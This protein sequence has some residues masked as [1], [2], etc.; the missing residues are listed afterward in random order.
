[1]VCI[2][3]KINFHPFYTF[4]GYSVFLLLVFHKFLQ[5]NMCFALQID[6]D[7]HD[8][9]IGLSHRLQD[10]CSHWSL[11]LHNVQL[12]PQNTNRQDAKCWAAILYNIF[13]ENCT[14]KILRCLHLKATR[15]PESYHQFPLIFPFFCAPLIQLQH[16]AMITFWAPIF[17]ESEG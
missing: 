12:A 9:F 17:M 2:S 4:L 5:P 6:S 3:L 8:G 15:T 16:C 13:N 11:T 7:I 1:M 14:S 10:H